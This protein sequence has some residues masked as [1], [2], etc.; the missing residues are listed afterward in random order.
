M[1]SPRSLLIFFVALLGLGGCATAPNAASPEQGAAA[2]RIVTSTGATLALYRNPLYLPAATAISA[3]IDTALSGQAVL[4]P[5]V[6]AKFVRDI[7]AKQNMPPIDVA[8]FVNLAT[9]VY[10][11]YFATYHPKLVLISDPTVQLYVRAFKD[12][13]NDAV[14]AVN[15]SRAP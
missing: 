13:L 11:A 4:T 7:C 6:I 2:L 5:E 10:Q 15:A 9:S 3:G 12:G 1:K 14:A 8:V